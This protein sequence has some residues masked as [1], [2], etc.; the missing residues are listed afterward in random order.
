MAVTKLD[1]HASLGIGLV[2]DTAA[3]ATHTKNPDG[4]GTRLRAVCHQSQ[5]ASVT[6]INLWLTGD[7]AG[8]PEMRLP[9]PSS[10]SVEWVFSGG[11]ARSTNGFSWNV[12]TDMDDAPTTAPGTP[13]PLQIV[14]S[15][16]NV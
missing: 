6:Y 14:T 12:T 3:A 11:G 2:R 10:G 7:P 13:S 1:S 4:T 15:G 5:T 8:A 9:C 16:G